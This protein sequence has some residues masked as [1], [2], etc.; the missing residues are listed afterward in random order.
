MHK[1]VKTDFKF[2]STKGWRAIIL[3]NS[4]LSHNMAF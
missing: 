1:S 2:S 4:L 3:G